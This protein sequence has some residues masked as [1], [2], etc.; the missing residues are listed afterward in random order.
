MTE[1]FVIYGAEVDDLTG[2]SVN[3]A[4]DFNVDGFDDII[5]SAPLAG[6]GFKQEI[7]ISYV[8]YGRRGFNFADVRLKNNLV[9]SSG[10]RIV[11]A[12]S[13]D[14]SGLSNCG[15]GNDFV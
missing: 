7:G 1:G 4:G 9:A 2:W 10:F 13:G 12:A 5:L 14:N 15:T 8:L 11:G 6:Y 3:G